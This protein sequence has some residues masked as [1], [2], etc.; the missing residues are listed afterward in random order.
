MV[1]LTDLDADHPITTEPTTAK[2]TDPDNPTVT[3]TSHP[4]HPAVRWI[5]QDD[6]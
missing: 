1:D 2:I 5:D 4:D 6:G 3:I